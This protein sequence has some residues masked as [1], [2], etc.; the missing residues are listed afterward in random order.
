MGKR[1]RISVPNWACRDQQKKKTKLTSKG[2]EDRDG[3]VQDLLDTALKTVAIGIY[4]D[5]GYS[6]KTGTYTSPFK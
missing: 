1:P 4:V 3:R 2:S 5:N 6:E